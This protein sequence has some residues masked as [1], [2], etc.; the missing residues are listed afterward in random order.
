MPD[1]RIATFSRTADALRTA[2]QWLTPR[3]NHS[4]SVV[5]ASTRAAAHEFARELPVKGTLGL[6]CMT[7]I[8]AAEELARSRVMAQQMGPLSRLGA[9]AL[10]ARVVH[11]L[12]QA[13]KL[14]YFAPVAKLPGFPAAL[15]LTLSD[16]RLAQ[17]HSASLD[18]QQDATRELRL[19]LTEYERELT[20]RRL[21]DLPL[22]L[23]LAIQ[24]ARSGDHFLL[25][26]PLLLLDVPLASSAHIAFLKGFAERTDEV[27]AVVQDSDLKT[28]SALEVSLSC[29]A[30]QVAPAGPHNA[31]TRVVRHLFSAQRPPESSHDASVDFF[32]APGEGLEAVEIVRRIRAK[33]ESGTPFDK[34]AILLRNVERYQPMLEEAMSRAGIPVYFSMGSARP[35]PSGRAFLALLG[36]AADGCSASG[37]AEYLS[38]GETPQVDSSGR[39]AQLELKFVL[40]EDEILGPFTGA[41]PLEEEDDGGDVASIPTPIAWERLLIDASVVGGRERWHRRLKG[42]EQEYQLQLAELRRTSGTTEVEHVERQIDRLQNLERFSLPLI[43][44]LAALPRSA[45][46]GEWLTARGRSNFLRL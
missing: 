26:H 41:A 20:E 13:G 30:E 19:F 9:E 43:D 33:A 31:L 21:A 25:G 17:I 22:L 6:H 14:K 34:V 24:S 16:L 18:Y 36:C 42:L 35:D 27:L 11:R 5:I 46:W 45:V 37:F 8:Q 2:S 7:L 38:I 15:A 3:V 4:E 12:N 44:M 39:P 23:S 40:P 1:K 28:L 29:A 32:S 10:A